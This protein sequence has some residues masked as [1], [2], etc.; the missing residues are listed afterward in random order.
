MA[1]SR[2]LQAVHR[3]RARPKL[4][5][6]FDRMAVPHPPTLFLGSKRIGLKAL[7]EFHGAAPASLAAV[8]TVDD[9][10]DKRSV[11]PAFREFCAKNQLP[12]VVL[13]RPSEI[14]E[15]VARYSPS[16]CL[17]VGWYWIIDSKL[18]G[19]VPGGFLGIH[20]SLL[21]K[22]RGNAP[23]VWAVL[24]GERR[25]GVSLFY[26]DDGIDTGDI[27]DQESFGIEDHETIA[28]V[29]A[30]AEV[31]A[32][33]LVRRHARALLNGTAPRTKQD[34]SEATYCSLR[35]PEDG[36]IDWRLPA[37][38]LLNFIRAQSAPYPGAFT[39]LADGKVLRVWKANP[40]PHPYYGVPGLVGMKEGSGVVVGCGDGAL[41]VTDCQV[42][43]DP[44]GPPAR[45]L[46]WG[47]RLG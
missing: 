30:K 43:G 24:R 22:Y 21:P 11:L 13:A 33:S 31:S 16:L 41:A 12:L 5:Q 20:A 3:L 4:T 40:F 17:V 18:L 36:L 39:T 9:G 44:P 19:S 37:R 28:D 38:Q 8:V 46:K 23:L 35:R 15:V 1:R 32:V 26:L 2:S 34:S 25:S 47:A 7:E 42:E 27:V 10:D 29:M 14:P 6:R 45:I